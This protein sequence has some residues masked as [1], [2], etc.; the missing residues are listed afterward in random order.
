MLEYIIKSGL[1]LIVLF[2]FY[3]LFLEAESFHGIKRF[4]LIMMLAVSLILPLVSFSYEVRIP[5]E[6]FGESVAL[7]STQSKAIISEVSWWQEHLPKILLVVY[8]TGFSIGSFRFY[9]NFKALITEAKKN[10]QLKDLPYIYVLLSR[11]LS[12]HS[13]FHYIFLNKEEFNN[14]EISEAVVEHEKA[15][16]DQKHSLDLLLLEFIHIVFWFNPV[17]IFIKHSVKLNHEFLADHSVLQKAYNPLE[18]SNILF[19]YSSG[20]HHNSLSSPINHSLIK[21]RIIMITKSFSLRRLLLKSFIFLPV[22]GGCVYLFNEEIVAKPVLAN[23]ET[24]NTI[25]G[26]F[27]QQDRTIT[28]QVK[29]ENILLNG[30]SVS[31]DNFSEA[32]NELTENWSKEDLKNPWF[33]IDFSNSNTNFIER[34]NREYRKSR[35]S[36]ISETEFLAPSPVAPGGTPP[37][38]PPP[39]VQRRNGNVPPPPPPAPEHSE[40][41]L[42]K[43]NLFSIKIKG[44]RLQVNGKST[45]LNDFKETLDDLTAA[46]TKEELKNSNFHMQI[47]DPKPGFMEKLNKEFKKTRMSKITGH[48]ILPPPPPAPPKLG[49][50]HRG[51]AREWRKMKDNE[52]KMIV[53]ER[54]K[55]RVIEKELQEDKKLTQSERAKMQADLRKKEI[56]INRR[57]KGIERDRREIERE[58][59]ALEKVQLLEAPPAPPDPLKAINELEEEGGSFY[60]DGKEISAQE[61]REL[62]NAKNYSKINILQTGGPDG[63]LEISSK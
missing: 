36:K 7:T 25:S 5:V 38:P 48:N 29:D 19:Q 63:K 12:P 52:R 9:R 42:Q 41:E 37:P 1:C 20:H 6:D 51:K 46:R 47:L 57:K 49:V 45:S 58:H 62:I 8:I 60:L 3:K 26:I 10:D 30:K 54:E 39:P 53:E 16:V 55:I 61:A 22:L 27:Q 44:D 13:F 34:L 40:H 28:L 21:K 4:Y 23:S 50:N 56:E 35:L 14:D 33:E 59:K 24:V 32:I 2:S 17:F 11:K 15:H 18:Y 43:E 31:L